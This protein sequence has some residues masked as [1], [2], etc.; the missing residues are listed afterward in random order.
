MLRLISYARAV[1]TDSGGLQEEAATLAVPVL[2]VRNETE[3]VY[4]V[5]AGAAALVGNIFDTIVETAA[6]LLAQGRA[7]FGRVDMAVQRGAAQ[8]IVATLKE[9]L[10]KWDTDGHR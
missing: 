9:L 3:W 4:L 10:Q 6:P 2:V 5:E 1:M 8:R 7:A